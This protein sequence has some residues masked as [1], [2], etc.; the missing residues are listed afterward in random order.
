MKVSTKTLA[1]LGLS[2]LSVVAAEVPQ[3][4]ENCPMTST[5]TCVLEDGRPCEALATQSYDSCGIKTLYYDFEYCNVGTGNVVR[6]HPQVTEALID[7]F[8]QT[9]LDLKVYEPMYKG[10][11]NSET[12]IVEVDTCNMG[13]T[14][15][16]LKVEGRLADSENNEIS[17]DG[18]YCYS[19]A[20]LKSKIRAPIQDES[21]EDDVPAKISMS[22]SCGYKSDYGTGD[23]SEN[24]CGDIGT[25][26][27]PNGQC[28][29]DVRFQYTVTNNGGGQARLQAL[30]DET[31][32]NLLQDENSV[33]IDV[34][35]SWEGSKIVEIDVCKEAVKQVVTKATAVAASVLG[36]STGT[37]KANYELVIP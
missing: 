10:C 19:Y 21:F 8:K 26:L 4:G 27:P 32:T 33:L 37:A 22:I 5:V 13:N 7:T 14:A 3:S 30:V 17:G 9:D 18:N 6:I 28:V 2:G 16:S 12:I 31:N 35:S 11:R 1:L 20:F 29:K 34:G 36:G 23:F 15:M 24:N 25:V